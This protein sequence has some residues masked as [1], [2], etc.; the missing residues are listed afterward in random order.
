MT[1]FN[2][3]YI[4]YVYRTLKYIIILGK[5]LPL[6]ITFCVVILRGLCP[7]SWQS[8]L[9]HKMCSIACGVI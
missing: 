9:N 4:L 5:Q 2:K 8:K 7:I 6:K 3:M 1:T